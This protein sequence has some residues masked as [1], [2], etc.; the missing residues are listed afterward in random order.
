MSGADSFKVIELNRK[1]SLLVLS[2]HLNFKCPQVFINFAMGNFGME[3]ENIPINSEDEND[4][5]GSM[6]AVDA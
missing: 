1:Y 3:M 2:L 4:D 5:T 6:K